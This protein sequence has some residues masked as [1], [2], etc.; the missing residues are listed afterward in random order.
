MVQQGQQ[1][2]FGF[3]P[4]KLEHFDMNTTPILQD[5][6]DNVQNVT[7]EVVWVGST[8]GRI[9]NVDRDCLRRSHYVRKDGPGIWE[10][11]NFQA[12]E[13]YFLQLSKFQ[14]EDIWVSGEKNCETQPL[15][16][17]L[18]RQFPP[19]E[20]DIWKWEENQA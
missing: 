8:G 9:L 7:L 14:W 20:G 5:E 13:L 1:G 10:V 4:R 12:T 2:E 6:K 17:V 3:G 18:T 19:V 15:T 16:I 11:E